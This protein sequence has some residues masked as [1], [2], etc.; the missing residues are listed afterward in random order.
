MHC[1]SGYECEIK[2]NSRSQYSPES[3]GD[4]N[5]Y[6]NFLLTYRTSNTYVDN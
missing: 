6:L 4:E 2:L 1:R 5:I 3:K